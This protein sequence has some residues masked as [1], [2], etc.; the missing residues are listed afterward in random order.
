M[1]SW[2]SGM[3]TATSGAD[4]KCRGLG[5]ERWAIHENPAGQRICARA[6][7]TVID[8]PEGEQARNGA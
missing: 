3:R 8:G 1:A 7:A 2:E 6:S 5:T 4:E